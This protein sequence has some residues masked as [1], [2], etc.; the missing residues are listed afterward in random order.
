MAQQT[1][2][3]PEQLEVRQLDD[4]KE[5]RAVAEEFGPERTVLLIGRPGSAKTFQALRSVLEAWAKQRRTA[6]E[7]VDALMP[8]FQDLPGQAA[9]LQARR[10][11][12]ARREL[13]ESYGAVT[14]GGV[15]EL[16][17][18]KAKNRAALANR[19]RSEGRVFAVPV[20]DELVYPLFQF[21]EEGRPLPVVAETLA[22][23]DR[24]GDLSDWQRALWFT[25]ANGWL[26]GRR[27]VELLERDPNTVIEAARREAELVS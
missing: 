8:R 1:I 13:L 12:E 15:A 2:E 25:S 4:L 18:S 26:A 20:D 9:V 6:A 27:P 19:W 14:S 5:I 10:N 23:L 3:R 21:S 22:A 16:A 24:S 11:A 7:L 17:R